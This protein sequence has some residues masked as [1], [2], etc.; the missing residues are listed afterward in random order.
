MSAANCDEHIGEEVIYKYDCPKVPISLRGVECMALIDSSADINALR[1]DVA[2]DA[3][4][5]ISDLLEYLK[6]LGIRTANDGLED[7]LG[8]VLDVPVKVGNVI[9]KTFFFVMRRLGHPCILGTT[10]C[11]RSS[12]NMNYRP[13]RLIECKLRNAE[14]THRVTFYRSRGHSRLSKVEKLL[15]T[16]RRKENDILEEVNITEILGKEPANL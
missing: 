16:T 6:G 9:N 8:L 4:L 12:L 15:T 10:F 13:S 11:C 2:L 7:F 5:I 14:G 1:E 3:G